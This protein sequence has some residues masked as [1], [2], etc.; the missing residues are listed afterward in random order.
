MITPD[1]Q[2]FQI[3]PNWNKK[4]L[5]VTKSCVTLFF[6]HSS[7]NPTFLALQWPFFT[8]VI[9]TC[10]QTSQITPNWNKKPLLDPKIS[11]KILVWICSVTS[12]FCRCP[13]NL[14]FLVLQWPFFTCII[15]TGSH[16]SQVTPNWNK[17]PLTRSK[18]LLENLS[19]KLFCTSFFRRC[20]T[21]LTFLALQCLIFN[22]I[23]THGSQTYQITSNSN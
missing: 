19:L 21:N 22:Q 20:P 3:T 1:Y 23:S 9:T 11:Y 10:S 16:T 12:F 7:A 2:T 14:I 6:R 17:K 15:T 8:Y 13:A 4:H 18:D 5:T